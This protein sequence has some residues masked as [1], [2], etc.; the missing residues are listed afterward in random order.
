MLFFLKMFFV[1]KEKFDINC[2][3]QEGDKVLIY[4]YIY[5]LLRGWI[6]IVGITRGD[7]GVSDVVTDGCCCCC[8]SC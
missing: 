7:T 1:E 3:E 8:C 4:L 6:T 5:F 2:L